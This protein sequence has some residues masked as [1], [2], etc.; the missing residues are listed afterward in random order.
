MMAKPLPEKRER[1]RLNPPKPQALSVQASVITFSET[2][3][4]DNPDGAGVVTVTVKV[5]VL[6]CPSLSVAVAVTVEVPTGKIEPDTGLLVVATAPSMASRA[7]VVKATATPPEPVASIVMSAGTVITGGATSFTVMLPS[8]VSLLV[9]QAMSRAQSWQVDGTKSA[10]IASRSEEHEA[11]PH[12]QGAA[13]IADRQRP[14]VGDTA[15]AGDAR[16]VR[17]RRTVEGKC[18]GAVGGESQR[19]GKVQRT[20]AAHAGREVALEGD[21]AVD[22]SGPGEESRAS[23]G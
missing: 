23:D 5:L 21:R 9:S 8:T 19:V 4:A 13:S 3:V 2:A 14:E 15:G 10:R 6:V 22:C 7:E 11:I 18:G 1:S 16:T 20:R 12:R 17:G